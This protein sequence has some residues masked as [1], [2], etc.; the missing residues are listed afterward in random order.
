MVLAWLSDGTVDSS[1]LP[2]FGV[3]VL[4]FNIIIFIVMYVYGM[5]H[6]NEMEN[7]VTHLLG[8]AYDFGK[9]G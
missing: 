1:N 2:L 8:E 4:V 9:F 7:T 6:A 3:G 5:M